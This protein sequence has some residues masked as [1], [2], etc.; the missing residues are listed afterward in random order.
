M[1][2]TH[3]PD[4]HH[5]DVALFYHPSCLEHDTGHHPENA[6]RIRAILS[7]L[8]RH[9]IPESSLFQPEPADLDLLAE[10]HDIRYIAAVERVAGAGGGY[11]DPD[12]YISTRSYEAALMSAAS[13]A[14]AVDHVMAG[15]QPAFALVRPPGHHALYSS[16]MGFC[17]FNNVAVAAQH[18]VRQHGLNRV[19]IID[20]DVHHGNGTQ[21]YFYSRSDV[22]FFSTH[23]Y[24]FYPGTGALGETGEGQ[25]K[26]YTVNVPLQ[27]GVDDAGYRRIF[28]QV[29]TPLAR[30][31]KPQLILI[32]AGYD[33]HAADPIG[34]MSVT[35]AGFYQMAHIVRHLADDI[36]ECQGRVAAVLEGGYNIE[37]LATSVLTTI[38]G[39]RRSDHEQSAEPPGESPPSNHSGAYRWRPAPDIGHTIDKVRQ[40]H[41]L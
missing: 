4:R 12:T 24:P 1:H 33:A 9:G 38:A 32:S 8:E 3:G 14:A 19:L 37:A 31:Y 10:V 11:W 41:G 39:L 30:R 34:G 28:E 29:L 17:L 18:A 13:A 25:G 36:Q 5:D 2:S 22:L 6:N 40:T 7:A 15:H 20:W 26:G 23:Q 16:A 35:A 27:A 21:D